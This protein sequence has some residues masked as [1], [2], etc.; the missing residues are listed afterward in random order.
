MAGPLV[1]DR[2]S[3]G[4]EDAG[5]PCDISVAG[6]CGQRLTNLKPYVWGAKDLRRYVLL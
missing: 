1:K 4:I 2:R 3:D 6:S 5:S